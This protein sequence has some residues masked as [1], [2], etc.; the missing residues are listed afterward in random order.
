MHLFI[1]EKEKNNTSEDYSSEA[2][3]TDDRFSSSFDF[4][5]YTS[6]ILKVLGDSNKIKT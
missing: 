2:F 4:L 3:Y 5:S 6:L 1:N